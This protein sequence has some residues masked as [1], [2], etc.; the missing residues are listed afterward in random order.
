MINNPAYT[1]PVC[2][3]SPEE[4]LRIVTD[5]NKLNDLRKKRSGL[6]AI[7][8]GLPELLRIRL[9]NFNIRKNQY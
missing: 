5:Y 9:S 3:E 1:E 4:Y 8:F 2:N 7:T 6:T